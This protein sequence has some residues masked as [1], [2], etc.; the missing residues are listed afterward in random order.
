[1]TFKNKDIRKEAPWAVMHAVWFEN[2]LRSF[3]N[4]SLVSMT[5]S[6]GTRP[7]NYRRNSENKEFVAESAEGKANI[8]A[9]AGAIAA[10]EKG[11]LIL[12]CIAHWII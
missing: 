3:L 8:D 1:M 4:T 5:H 10:L 6:N 11:I 12:G 9:T 2:F 7:V